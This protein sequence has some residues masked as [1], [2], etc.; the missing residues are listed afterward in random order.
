MYVLMS[1]NAVNQEIYSCVHASSVYPNYRNLGGLGPL[2]QEPP[3]PPPCLL[4]V[5]ATIHEIDNKF[6]PG[7]PVIVI[8]T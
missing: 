8:S 6:P 1:N 2:T 4:Y 5:S 3:S 7:H